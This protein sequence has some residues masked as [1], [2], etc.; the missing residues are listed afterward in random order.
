MPITRSTI[1]YHTS[2]LRSHSFCIN[3]SLSPPWNAIN[4]IVCSS[5]GVSPTLVQPLLPLFDC[6]WNPPNGLALRRR[7]SDKSGCP[8]FARRGWGRWSL[9]H[10]GAERKRRKEERRTPRDRGSRWKG[11]AL[12]LRNCKRE[13]PEESPPLQGEKCRGVVVCF[14]CSLLSFLFLH[15][16]LPQKL[17]Q[18]SRSVLG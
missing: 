2:I 7:E 17:G 15:F 18:E 14:R 5:K 12:H 10:L 11:R 8:S 4:H 9:S 6:G 13:G 1:N 16:Q 3:Y